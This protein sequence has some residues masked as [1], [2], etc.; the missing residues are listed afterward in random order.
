MESNL[1]IFHCQT[2]ISILEIDNLQEKELQIKFQLNEMPQIKISSFNTIEGIDRYNIYKGFEFFTRLECFSA[3]QVLPV[4]IFL[5]NQEG[6]I[7]C[8]C[9]FDLSPMVVDAFRRNSHG[10]PGIE[11]YQV[12]LPLQDRYNH[13]LG[14]AHL[15]FAVQHFST[16]ANNIICYEELPTE[17]APE[18]KKVQEEKVA[19]D[20]D[21]KKEKKATKKK[22]PRVNPRAADLFLLNQKYLNTRVELVEQVRDLENQVKRMETS[23]RRQ[24]Y[25]QK[26]ERRRRRKEMDPE[27]SYYSGYSSTSQSNFRTDQFNR[28]EEFTSIPM[29][30][31]NETK[32]SNKSLTN[33]SNKNN[34]EEFLKRQEAYSEKKKQLNDQNKQQGIT[35]SKIHSKPK[36]NQSS[37]SRKSSQANSMVQE[38]D[39]IESPRKSDSNKVSQ[40][41]TTSSKTSSTVNKP[42]EFTSTTK[43]D[44]V[45]STNNMNNGNT[46][47]QQN[48]ATNQYVDEDFSTTTKS[49]TDSKPK[50]SIS[51]T[52]TSNE[53]TIPDSQINSNQKTSEISGISDFESESK[54]KSSSSSKKSLSSKKSSSPNEVSMISDFENDDPKSKEKSDLDISGIESTKS[55]SSRNK[56]SVIEIDD[57]DSIHDTQS[58]I[59]IDVD[60][61]GSN[62][63]SR[64]NKSKSS[65]KS[66]SS[67]GSTASKNSSRSKGSTTSKSSFKIDSS[68]LSK[69]D[70]SSS[71]SKKSNDIDLSGIM[72][73][74]DK[75]DG[76][77]PIDS[78]LKDVLELTSST[79]NL[80]E[81]TDK[82]KDTK[83]DTKK[84]D[85]EKKTSTQKKSSDDSFS[86]IGSSKTQ[87]S[88][89]Y[90]D[91]LSILSDV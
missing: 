78:D 17:V 52:T 18:P 19:D 20:S 83:K 33:K 66:N 76:S 55:S 41:L 77:S 9:G 70:N 50:D 65:I 90:T 36:K 80:I 48:N 56:S 73:E 63:S 12:P 71:K 35:T 39:A 87:E 91:I 86:S 81:K 24:I 42:S 11:T 3:F 44:T 62:K 27:F 16:D 49:T 61:D 14:Q 5:C 72:D 37:H 53:V 2:F 8:A 6:Q 85:K 79:M 82:K 74:L 88:A 43:S 59:K 34:L 21:N 67:K 89:M 32:K 22:F 58:F 51:F 46:L 60:S 4:Y 13:I 69:N 84:E 68:I 29:N 47:P 31:N 45:A 10:K 15:E 23:R 40:E 64:S 75:N 38:F 57:I 26:E 25:K 7:I 30:K 28:V 1:E 54:H